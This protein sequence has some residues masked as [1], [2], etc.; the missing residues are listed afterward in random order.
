RRALRGQRS[1]HRRGPLS[2]PVVATAGRPQVL[3]IPRRGSAAGAV[4][5]ARAEEDDLLLPGLGRGP[6]GRPRP[7]TQ[8]PRSSPHWVTFIATAEYGPVETGPATPSPDRGFPAPAPG[9]PP[10]AAPALSRRAG[11]DTPGSVP[12]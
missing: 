8:G 9:V 2:A 11:R 10:A 5:R 6:R 1:V 7:P 4:G 12:H 3:G